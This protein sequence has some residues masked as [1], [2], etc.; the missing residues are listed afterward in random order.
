MISEDEE[1][2]GRFVK[3]QF[4]IVGVLAT[5]TGVNFDQFARTEIYVPVDQARAFREANRDLL[6][7]WEKLL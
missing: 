7:E 5:E 3:S 6:S 1:S 4:R 2:E